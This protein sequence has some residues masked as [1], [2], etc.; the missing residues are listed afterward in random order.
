MAAPP[1]VES[2]QARAEP[3]EGLAR[4]VI[5]NLVQTYS[6]SAD[7]RFRVRRLAPAVQILTR[8]SAKLL[9]R[10]RLNAKS[11]A[12]AGRNLTFYK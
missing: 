12:M 7:R 3:L 11:T 1:P 9:D 5:S 4:A 2:V 8:H 10:D 6:P